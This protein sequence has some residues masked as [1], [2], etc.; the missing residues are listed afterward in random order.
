MKSVLLSLFLFL[1]I[2]CFSQIKIMKA[3]DGW[4]LRVDSALALIAKTDVNTYIRVIDVVEIIDFWISPYSSN[5]VSQD[6]NIIYISTGDVKMNSIAN[7]ACVLVH[8]SLHLNYLLHPIE[9]TADEEELKCY[10]YELSFINKLPT[11]EPWLQA[12]AVEQIHK[13]SKTKKHE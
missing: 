1:S 5:N 2:P 13:L 9:Q 12:N 11:P 6:G 3:G 8:E 7:L 4:D 10:I